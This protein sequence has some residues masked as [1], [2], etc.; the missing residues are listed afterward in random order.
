MET[1]D[2]LEEL[3]PGLKLLAPIERMF[4]KRSIL[5]DAV[6]DGQASH[7][8]VSKSYDAT[9]HF[10][11]ATADVVSMYERITG[12]QLD[13]TRINADNINDQENSC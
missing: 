12:E 2:P 7:V 1:N 5:Y 13:L 9:S 4:V 11:S 3:Q 6:D 8:F 10:E